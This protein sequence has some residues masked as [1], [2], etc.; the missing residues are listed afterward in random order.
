MRARKAQ[1]GRRDPVGRGRCWPGCG[2]SDEDKPEAGAAARRSAGET[3]TG[4]KLKVD[5]FLD[6]ATIRC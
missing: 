1:S 5:T 2:G 6:P 3:E 4:M